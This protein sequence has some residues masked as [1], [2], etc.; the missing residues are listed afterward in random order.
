MET[1]RAPRGHV[2]RIYRQV[3]LTLSLFPTLL[4]I[5]SYKGKWLLA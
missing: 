5:V 2:I 1:G 3:L 4:D